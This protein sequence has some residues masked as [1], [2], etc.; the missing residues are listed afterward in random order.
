[1]RS[2]PRFKRVEGLKNFLDAVLVGSD[3]GAHVWGHCERTEYVAC[4]VHRGDTGY[5]SSHVMQSTAQVIKPAGNLPWMQITQIKD[6]PESS[7]SGSENW[8]TAYS[9][10]PVSG[11]NKVLA[12]YDG[13]DRHTVVRRTD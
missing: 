6:V 4:S 3:G 9:S 10:L 11:E 1:M 13:F 2:A 5:G 12:T 7:P 8:A